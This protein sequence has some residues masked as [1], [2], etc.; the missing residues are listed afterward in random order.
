MLVSFASSG[1]KCGSERK[2]GQGR[3]EIANKDKSRIDSWRYST[4]TNIFVDTYDT[5]DNSQQYHLATQEL[6]SPIFAQC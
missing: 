3:K 6:V 4:R 2:M 5:M 1:Y